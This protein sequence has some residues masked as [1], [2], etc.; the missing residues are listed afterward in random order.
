MCR[1]NLAPCPRLSLRYSTEVKPSTR[2]TRTICSI[3]TTPLLFA[4]F[5][6][7]LCSHGLRISFI[8][9]S[10]IPWFR[11][12]ATDLR[13]WSDRTLFCFVLQAFEAVRPPFSFLELILANILSFF[14]RRRN[15]T[16]RLS[17]RLTTSPF[18]NTAWALTSTAPRNP[19][20]SSMVQGI[21]MLSSKLSTISPKRSQIV[22]ISFQR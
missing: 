17:T 7:G 3:R 21:I 15:T 11:S 14:S 6:L 22:R 5:L 1:R 8:Y 4:F 12:F 2:S 20:R 13:L 10:S 16:S 19:K 9:R 18:T